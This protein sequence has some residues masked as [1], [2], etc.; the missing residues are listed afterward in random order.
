[1]SIRISHWKRHTFQNAVRLGSVL[2][3]GN[4]GGV[5]HKSSRVYLFQQALCLD[6]YRLNDISTLGSAFSIN[7]VQCKDPAVQSR[8]SI[9]DGLDAFLLSLP[10]GSTELFIHFPAIS[11]SKPLTWASGRSADQRLALDQRLLSLRFFKRC[12]R[13]AAYAGLWS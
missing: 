2:F 5:L 1:M 4:L 11:V 12:F 13:I 9:Y 3:L 10:R 6:Y 8:L 7:E